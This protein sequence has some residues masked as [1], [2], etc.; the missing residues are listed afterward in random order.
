MFA[1]TAQAL[2]LIVGALTS[3][4][5]PCSPMSCYNPLQ[6]VLTATEIAGQAADSVTSALIPG[7]YCRDNIGG[8]P[9]CLPSPA[10]KRR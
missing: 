10:R 4:I 7:F 8:F 2:T 5:T 3:P 9:I 1:E 6:P